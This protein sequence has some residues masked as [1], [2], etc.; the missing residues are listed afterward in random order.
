[1]GETRVARSGVSEGAV[2]S[3]SHDCYMVCSAKDL[4][5]CRCWGLDS[6]DGTGTAVSMQTMRIT[7]S[8]LNK[9]QNIV[10]QAPVFVPCADSFICR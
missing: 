8:M 1:M 3:R 4:C 10:L 6:L 9:V 7:H 5:A 2:K